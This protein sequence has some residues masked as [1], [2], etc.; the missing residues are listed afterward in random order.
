MTSTH[1]KQFISKRND[2]LAS[3]NVFTKYMK[4]KQLNLSHEAQAESTSSANI[5]IILY[6]R[7]YQWQ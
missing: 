2:G 1:R 7:S 3:S 4:T 5:L 6:M